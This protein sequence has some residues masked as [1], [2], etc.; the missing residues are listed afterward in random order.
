LTDGLKKGLKQLKN[1]L[2]DDIKNHV[3]EAL[4]EFVVTEKPPVAT[5]KDKGSA[6][7]RKRKNPTEDGE[8]NPSIAPIPPKLDALSFDFKEIGLVESTPM[9]DPDEFNLDTVRPSFSDLFSYRLRL[10]TEDTKIFHCP[11]VVPSTNA[12]DDWIEA[13]FLQLI[14]DDK[15]G[16]SEYEYLSFIIDDEPLKN[17]EPSKNDEFLSSLIIRTTLFVPSS[18]VTRP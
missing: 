13:Q 12:E 17:N 8:A 6:P 15:K 16:V 18:L 11:I 9:V 7:L 1:K 4:R 10:Q 5:S 14:G 2:N 3:R